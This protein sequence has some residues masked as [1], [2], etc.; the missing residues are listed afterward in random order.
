METMSYL[1]ILVRNN[2]SDAVAYGSKGNFIL[3]MK[4]SHGNDLHYCSCE[5][6]LTQ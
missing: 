6:G 2:S 3:I 4:P 1:N 5:L